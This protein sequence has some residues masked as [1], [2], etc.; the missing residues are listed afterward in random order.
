MLGSCRFTRCWNHWNVSLPRKRTLEL[1]CQTVQG[2]RQRREH[3]AL[4]V[5]LTVLDCKTALSSLLGPLAGRRRIYNGVVLPAVGSL[6]HCG[7]CTGQHQGHLLAPS[8]KAP[9]AFLLCQR[10]KTLIPNIMKMILIYLLARVEGVEN[11]LR[12]YM[13]CH[14][15]WLQGMILGHIT[16]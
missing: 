15:T 3:W 13:Y 5:G 4:T 8:L 16:C 14:I 12:C 7:A 1:R 2:A 9:S 10:S 6:C 11:G